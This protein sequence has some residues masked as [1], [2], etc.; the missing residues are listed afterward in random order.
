MVIFHSYVKLPEGRNLL[1]FQHFHTF[2]RCLMDGIHIWSLM[3]HTWLDMTT[4]GQVKA[5]PQPRIVGTHHGIWMDL[6]TSFLGHVTQTWPDLVPIWNPVKPV[7]WGGWRPWF[8]ILSPLA[9][10][11]ICNILLMGKKFLH[12]LGWNKTCWNPLGCLLYVYHLS[13]GA[14]F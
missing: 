14:G 10:V 13:T 11:C 4:T 2:S 7:Y 12:H 6:V 1:G 3:D 5:P 8:L 9:Y